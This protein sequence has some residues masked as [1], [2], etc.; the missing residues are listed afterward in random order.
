M[1]TVSKY[2]VTE[3]ERQPMLLPVDRVLG[4]VKTV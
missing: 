1:L 4:G 3:S 2:R